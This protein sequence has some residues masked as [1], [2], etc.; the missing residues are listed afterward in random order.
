MYP[1]KE[2]DMAS[3]ATDSDKPPRPTREEALAIAA[4]RKA[5]RRDRTLRLRKGVAVLAVA[6][7][8][9]P[10]AVIYDHV[11]TGTDPALAATSATVATTNSPATTTVS[12]PVTTSAPTPVTTQQS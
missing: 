3:H 11:A 2:Q 1:R 6:V 8:V 12:T 5:L 10:F 4:K 9:V 7:F